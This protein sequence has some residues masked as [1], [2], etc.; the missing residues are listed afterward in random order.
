MQSDTKTAT[1]VIE[2]GWVICPGCH[3]QKLLRVL[4]DTSATH[5]PLYCKRCRR[6]HIVN[7]YQSL[8]A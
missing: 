2:D 8:S 1:L 7:I 3:R 6:E 5:L 4:P